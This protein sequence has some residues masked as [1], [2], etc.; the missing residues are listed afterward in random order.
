MIKSVI[1]DK[2]HQLNTQTTL[3]IG[4]HTYKS[5]NWLMVIRSQCGMHNLIVSQSNT[6]SAEM[7]KLWPFLRECN[8]KLIIQERFLFVSCRDI[9]ENLLVDLQE[10]VF[11]NL[12]DLRILW[13]AWKKFL[14]KM[15]WISVLLFVKISIFI[16]FFRSLRSN[17]IRH[18]KRDVFK[19]TTR[20][21]H[22]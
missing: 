8:V 6:Y 22:L 11:D 14:I 2:L 9:G 16:L 13:V 5:I 10:G 15:K 21:T 20:L 17:S 12:T 19:R 3:P 18:I 4:L 7:P 1:E